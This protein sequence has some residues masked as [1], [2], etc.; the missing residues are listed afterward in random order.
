MNSL[1]ILCIDKILLNSIPEQLES[2][3]DTLKGRILER[4]LC[5]NTPKFSYRGSLPPAP[6]PRWLS[7][8]VNKSTTHLDLST[9]PTLFWS[10]FNMTG[11]FPF[12]FL[13]RCTQLTSLKINAQNFTVGQLVPFLRVIGARLKHLDLSRCIRLNDS[14]L[15][16]ISYYCRQLQ[17][18]KL[19][20]CIGIG[21]AVFQRSMA[22]AM[23]LMPTSRSS[24][25]T[26]APHPNS[27]AMMRMSNLVEL[28]LTGCK[29][30]AIRN[31]CNFSFV[32]PSLQE[33]SFAKAFLS[34]EDGSMLVQTLPASLL[35]LDLSFNPVGKNTI[36]ALVP[37]SRK[38]LTTY[39]L[40]SLNLDYCRCV[41]TIDIQTLFSKVQTTL[42]TLSI[43]GCLQIERQNFNVISSTSSGSSKRSNKRFSFNSYK[44]DLYERMPNV[45]Y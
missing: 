2:F 32:F 19:Q 36:S 35:S 25:G 1:E 5:P 21:G 3:D 17:T 14:S 40:R 44:R 45:V 12:Q 27:F 34:D 10:Q 13:E 11:N 41:S 4:L 22:T 33:F 37:D 26:P 30:I 38:N 9:V 42:E 28:D 29:S 18:L 16:F 39:Q 7:A 6:S 15:H 31:M 8:L 20:D 24:D 43:T 23:A